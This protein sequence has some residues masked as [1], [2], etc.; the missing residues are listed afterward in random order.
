MADCTI[1]DKHLRRIATALEIG[2]L[3]KTNEYGTSLETV[4]NARLIAT[5]PEMLEA[6]K[7]ARSGLA[8]FCSGATEYTIAKID[9][10]ICRAEGRE[11]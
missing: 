7:E 2:R 5:A 8:A 9:S 10:I 3:N 4:S 1:R 6:L 11:E